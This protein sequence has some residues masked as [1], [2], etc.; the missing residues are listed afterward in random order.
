MRFPSPSH[1][2]FFL[3]VLRSKT[4]KHQ[5]PGVRRLSTA[6]G[7]FVVVGEKLN[8]RSDL[9]GRPHCKGVA[10]GVARRGA[11]HSG[12]RTLRIPP[13]CS[14]PVSHSC[15]PLVASFVHRSSVRTGTAKLR[16]EA[17][18]CACGV[19]GTSGR[20]ASAARRGAWAPAPG[21]AARGNNSASGKNTERKM[22][23]SLRNS[24]IAMRYDFASRL[25]EVVDLALLAR[26]M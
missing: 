25:L 21:T 9:S 1:F 13:S 10:I 6:N 23:M 20:S 26:V 11:R 2:F 12:E 7:I 18:S 4:G 15:G 24:A 14:G 5:P 22:V 8:K 16:K 3:P 19:R 17:A